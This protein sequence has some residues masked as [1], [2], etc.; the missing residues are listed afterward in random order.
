MSV[1]HHQTTE[2]AP[3]ELC[4]SSTFTILADKDRD[5]AP[6]QTVLC[7]DCG[8]VFTNPRPSDEALR[9]FYR[10]SYRQEYKN[11]VKPKLK[12]VYRAGSVALDRL[13]YLIPLL[14][15]GNS[16]LDLGSG[17]GEMLFI[18][19][20]LGYHVEGIEPNVGYGSAARD[21]L[22]LPVQVTH[23]SEAKVEPGSQDVVTAFHV[24]EHLPHPIEALATMASWMRDDGLM[25]IEVPHALSRCQWPQSRYHIGHL[26]HFSSSTLTLAGQKAGLEHVDS[27]TSRDGGNLMVIFRKKRDTTAATAAII[28][29]HSQRVL[30]HYQKH[31]NLRHA[32]TPLP[33][34]RPLE[35]AAK[36]LIEKTTLLKFDNAHDVLDHLVKKAKAIQ[37]KAISQRGHRH[38]QENLGTA[39]CCCEG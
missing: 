9:D 31:T 5:G 22:G 8:L 35:K 13:D 30:R 18:L 26:H 21:L 23:Y 19:R 34:I 12:H 10:E 20:G 28:P 36:G 27:F 33:Y 29:G 7:Q 11:A 14:K 37:H 2:L 25:L 1:T 15:P 24:V 3:C 38:C 32:L 4:Q 6:L 39:P 17:G 16:I